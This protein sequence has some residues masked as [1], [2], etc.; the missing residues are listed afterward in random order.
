MAVQF[1]LQC[2]AYDQEGMDRLRR[3]RIGRLA[4]MW[5]GIRILFWLPGIVT[6]TAVY[7]VPLSIL[8]YLVAGG[9][10][11]GHYLVVSIT[12]ACYLTVTTLRRLGNI[13]AGPLVLEIRTQPR[14]FVEAASGG[15]RN[16]LMSVYAVYVLAFYGAAILLIVGLLSPAQPPLVG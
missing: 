5:F 4:F 11:P 13:W 2:Q 15:I 6:L 14:A 8:V 1:T 12:G 9:P 16:G 7:W 3:T 10:Y